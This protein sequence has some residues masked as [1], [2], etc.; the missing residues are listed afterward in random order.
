MRVCRKIKEGEE[1]L[2][3]YCG[4][5]NNFPSKVERQMRLMKTWNFA[6]NCEVCSLIGEEFIENEKA[7]KKITDLHNAIRIKV[8]SDQD[9]LALQDAKEKLKIMK[10]MKREMILYLSGALMDCCVAAAYC[11]L[12]SSSAAKLMKKAKDLSHLFGD[13]YIY[14][15]HEREQEWEIGMMGR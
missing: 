2:A 13:L 8:N 9:E 10:S 1:I 15:Y 14:E 11:K 4:D 6:C 12:P 7:R 3:S 5:A